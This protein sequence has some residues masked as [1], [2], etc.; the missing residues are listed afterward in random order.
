MKKDED[1]TYA[2]L[3]AKILRQLGYKHVKE[4]MF[5]GLTDIQIDNRARSIM[6][7]PPRYYR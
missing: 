4:E 6:S 7:K 5:D 1:K 3:K 2:E